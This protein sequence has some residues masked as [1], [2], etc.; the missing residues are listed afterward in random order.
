MVKKWK[1]KKNIKKNQTEIL[2]LKN[3]IITLKKLNREL[4]YQT[5][6]GRRISEH[7]K[8]FTHK[9]TKNKEKIMEKSEESLKDL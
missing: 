1:E 3:L 6:S 8:L 7:L 2:E 5:W 4:W 9:K